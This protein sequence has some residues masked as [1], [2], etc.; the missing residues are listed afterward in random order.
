MHARLHELERMVEADAKPIEK[1]RLN[2][3]RY[4][5]LEG[6]QTQ[7]GGNQI[8]DFG[9][10]SHEDVSFCPQCGRYHRGPQCAIFRKPHPVQ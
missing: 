4:T 8:V 9:D 2:L 7:R 1:D 10:G 5:Y 3:E 6:V